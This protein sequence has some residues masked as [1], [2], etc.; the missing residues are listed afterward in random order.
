MMA[1]IVS[2][3]VFITGLWMGTVL[4]LDGTLWN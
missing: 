4:G 2:V 3:L 1:Y